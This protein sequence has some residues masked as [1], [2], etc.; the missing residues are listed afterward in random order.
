MSLTIDLDFLVT[1][2]QGLVQ[3][4]SVN[5]SLV[6][7]APGEAELADYVGRTLARL[8][9]EVNYLEPAAGRVS[10]VGRWPGRGGG[11]SLMLN[12][13]LDTV[14]VDDMAEPF[15]GVVRQGR[16]YGR[17]AYDMKGGLAAQLAAA[18]ALVEQGPALAG[19]L[20]VTAVAD[21]EY[22]SLGTQTVL[23]QWR[24]DG[25]IVTEPTGLQI[26][27][28]HKGF[29]WLT[30][31]T[32]GRAAHGSR[33]DLGLD[34]NMRLGRFLAA[35][36]AFEQALRARPPHPLVGPPS[37]HVATLHGGTELSMY[38]ASAT[39]GIER[40]TIPGETPAQV[41]AEIQAILDRLAAADPDFQASLEVRLVR[42]PFAVP[43]EA[44]IVRAVDAAAS[45][46]LGYRPAQVGDTPW[47]DAALLA[48]A[49]VETVV[50]GPAGAGAHAAVEWVDLES[51]HLLARIL[52]ESV[53]RYC[54]P[55]RGLDQSRQRHPAG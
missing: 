39:A 24:P 2:L 26:C 44:A 40:R 1:V 28:A 22:A 33:F 11:R 43:A 50:I 17:G 37:L 32:T 41:T 10:V 55:E 25:A 54:G 21:E 6:P 27:R 9:L 12:A 42:E 30:V 29:V 46:V 18:K 20:L 31:T 51:T 8:G 35:L 7:G 5:P 19:D 14:G 15:A 53:I 4:N 3:I 38:A 52:A 23:R 48:D 16:L 13:H 45:K 49:G 36:D 47:M 34:A